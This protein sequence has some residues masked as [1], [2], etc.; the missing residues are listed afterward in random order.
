MYLVFPL[1]SDQAD[2][3]LIDYWMIILRVFTINT[4]LQ[5]VYTTHTPYQIIKVT[6]S[7]SYQIP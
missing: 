4:A 5:F 6:R 2:D 7:T 1:L 3:Y